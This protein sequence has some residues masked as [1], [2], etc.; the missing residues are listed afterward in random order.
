MVD[1]VG[2]LDDALSKHGVQRGAS[3]RRASMLSASEE[4]HCIEVDEKSLARADVADP[5]DEPEN[6]DDQDDN[7]MSS[8]DGDN[9]C[10]CACKACKA[11][12]CDACSCSACA[13]DRCACDQTT[14]AHKKAA[15]NRRRLQLTE[16]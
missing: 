9:T 2:T 14:S 5:D 12:A 15:A 16:V 6:V 10:K 4:K 8:E 13:C 7:E 11:G 3:S 1:R